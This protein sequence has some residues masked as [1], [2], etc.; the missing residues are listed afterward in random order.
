MGQPLVH[1]SATVDSG[2]DLG[3]DVKI[4]HFVHISENASIGARS[5]LGQNVFVGRGVVLGAGV[6]VQNGVSIFEGVQV[7]DDAFLGPGCV[8]TNVLTPR[9][10]Y[11]TRSH[12]AVTRVGR[13]ATVGAN[14]TVVC[15]NTLGQYAFVGAGAVVV[16]SV[17]DFGLA[18]GNPA[19][20]IGYMCRCGVRLAVQPN[21]C[22]SIACAECGLGYEVNIH[23]CRGV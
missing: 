20:L 2:V 22:V 16:E 8:F 21:E 18:V 10:E 9:S 5:S 11:P 12:Y 14:A 1:A 6:R 3:P 19:Q 23:G 15:G 17:P 7:Q 13:G 4:W